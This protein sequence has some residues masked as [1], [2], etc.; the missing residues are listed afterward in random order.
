M[1]KWQKKHDAAVQKFGDAIADLVCE[2]DDSE[3]INVMDI[4]GVLETHKMMVFKTAS[5]KVDTLR[6]AETL[7]SIFGGFEDDD[8]D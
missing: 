4:I 3:Y 6:M 7:D 2:A 1:S 5:D 8:A